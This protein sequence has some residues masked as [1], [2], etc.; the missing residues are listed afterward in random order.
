MFEKE[1]KFIGDFCLNQVKYL[2]SNFT[3]QKI[4]ATELHPAIVRYISA[5]LEFMIY[6]DRRKLLQHSY[7][8][9]SGKDI[10]E[11]FR[12]INHEIKKT[13]RIAFDDAKKLILQAVSFN[14]NY[15]VKPN[16]S[17]SQ[18][19][20]ND[21]DTVSIDELEMMLNYIYYYEHLKKVLLAYLTKRNIVQIS[22]TEFDLILK[23]IDQELVKSNAEQLIQNALAS[24]GDFFNIGGV[25]RN[26]VSPV[27]VEIFL[28]EKSLFTHLLK[29]RKGISDP[30]KRKYTIEAIK[31]SIYTEDVIEDK[32]EKDPEVE[33]GEENLGELA[34]EHA[35]NLDKAGVEEIINL[36]EEE[37][38]LA[39]YEEELKENTSKENSNSI[40][41]DNEREIV[42]EESETELADEN[43]EEPEE[44]SPEKEIV[45]E[46][47]KEYFNGDLP[48][49]EVQKTN[50]E[51]VEAKGDESAEF[52]KER[53]VSSLEDELLEVFED[54][55]KEDTTNQKVDASPPESE[56]EK[57]IKLESDI[58]EKSFEIDEQIEIEEESTLTDE[59]SIIKNIEEATSTEE[60]ASQD[61]RKFE[62]VESGEQTEEEKI[63]RKKD[64]F[65]YLSKKETRKILSHI[66]LTDEEDFT[67]TVEKIME[68]G[69]YKEASDI[70]KSVFSSYKVSPYAKDAVNFTNAVSNYFRQA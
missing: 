8:D 12:K 51:K 35:Q 11:H 20:Y 5:E 7:F 9:Y 6:S 61:E 43:I 55:D 50:Q 32:D 70:L 30:S 68:C 57:E 44:K 46:M 22:K 24:I 4:T 2:G 16:W 67:N 15:V 45:T 13:K 39:L 28:K 53:K 38:L 41:D 47:I 3:F 1:I 63:I 56:V 34:D 31:R 48:E 52:V 27:A 19:I 69:S 21:Q 33:K 18:L 42:D 25:E 66:F 23:K 54:L 60:A 64:L 17:L 62:E 49:D 40:A 36:E 37:A 29:L 59:D 10:S 14:A 26:L 65:S 58:E